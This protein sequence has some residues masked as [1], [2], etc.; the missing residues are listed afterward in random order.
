MADADSFAHQ[1]SRNLVIETFLIATS[2]AMIRNIVFA[3]SLFREAPNTPDC[4]LRVQSNAPAARLFRYAK[5]ENSR[6]A[7]VLKT[8]SDAFIINYQNVAGS[9]S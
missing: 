4:P 1:T 6:N 7:F 9:L 2:P 3:E 5:L 8:R